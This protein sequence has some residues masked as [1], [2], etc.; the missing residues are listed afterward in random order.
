[1]RMTLVRC[2]MLGAVMA[3]SSAQAQDR[4]P[5]PP[6][7]EGQTILN[8][9]ATEHTQV[10]QDTLIASLNVTKDGPDAAAI[11]NDINVLMQQALAKAKAVTGIQVSNGQY[12]V[13][14]DNPVPPQPLQKNGQPKAPSVWHGAQSIELKG[15]QAEAILKLT[16]E[17]QAMGLTVNNLLYTLSPEKSDEAQE[18]LMEQALIKVK[19]K[20]ERA[21]AAL[22]KSK[23][24]LAEI[25]VDSTSN[26]MPMMRMAAPMADM[27]AANEAQAPSAEPGMADI[28][29]TVSARALL[30]P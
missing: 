14:Q 17:L 19:K 27:Q 8:V 16:G 9:S 5:P 6:L 25:T 11:Q 12:Y 2:L 1:M 26:A 30:K 28:D 20:A 22:G 23:V 4:P 18:S 7:P 24:A 10:Q 3:A 15:T 29:L 21:A 13:Y